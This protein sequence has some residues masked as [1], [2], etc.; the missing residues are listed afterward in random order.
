MN[1]DKGEKLFGLIQILLG[2]FILFIAVLVVFIE[3]V[4]KSTGGIGTGFAIIF[5]IPGS[6]LLLKSGFYKLGGRPLNIYYLILFITVIT[7]ILYFLYYYTDFS[8]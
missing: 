6:Y 5:I 3:V 2:A 7:L 1:E 8:L 4:E